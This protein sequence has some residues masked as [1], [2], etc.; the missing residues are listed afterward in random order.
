MKVAK[1]RV[2]LAQL[3]VDDLIKRLHETRRAL[4]V[5][6]LNA[7]SAHVK[8]YSQFKKLRRQLARVQTIL[9]QKVRSVIS[10]MGTQNG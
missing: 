4:L 9:R 1:E 2:E 3:S 10:Q 6:R 5:L 8:D 7:V